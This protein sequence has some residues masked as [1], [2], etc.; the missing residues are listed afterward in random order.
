MQR[1]QTNTNEK[2][3]QQPNEPNKDYNMF[4]AYRHTRQN[5]KTIQYLV[6]ELEILRNY[7]YHLYYFYQQCFFVSRHKIVKMY[8]IWILIK[9]SRD[10]FLSGFSEKRA[11]KQVVK[12]ISDVSRITQGTETLVTRNIRESASLNRKTVTQSTNTHIT[13]EKP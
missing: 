7:I 1:A 3:T 10:I 4:H 6:F 11:N 5:K 13:L 12:L 8:G 2:P 9:T